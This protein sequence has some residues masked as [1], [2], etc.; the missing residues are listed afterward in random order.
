MQ[1]YLEA[2]LGEEELQR[3]N[4]ALTRPPLAT[5]L[6]V[7]TLRVTP[8]VCCILLPLPFAL[9][10]PS[11]SALVCQA[12]ARLCPGSTRPAGPGARVA[13]ISHSSHS[14]HYNYSTQELLDRLP[15]AMS[16]EDQALVEANPRKP[17]IHPQLPGA[18]IVPGTGPH[19]IDYSCTGVSV[20]VGGGGSRWLGG[21]VVAV[22]WGWV[23][24]SWHRA[25]HC[26]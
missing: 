24:W 16:P 22:G 5:C 10:A 7:N 17:Y 4:E 14:N 3:I 18:I 25:A 12:P 26:A 15:G 9:L 20:C 21:V 11:N 13:P 19:A 1:S 6:R 8:E 2:C 23:C